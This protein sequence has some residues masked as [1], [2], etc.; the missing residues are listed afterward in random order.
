MIAGTVIWPVKVSIARTN[1][2]TIESVC[3]TTSTRWRSHRSRNAPAN[4]PMT[5][6]GNCPAKPTTPSTIGEPV[7]R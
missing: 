7:N 1:D 3:V 2:C 5:K 4:G 6:P